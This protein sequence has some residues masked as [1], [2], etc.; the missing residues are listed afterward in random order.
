M[1]YTYYFVRYS[2]NHHKPNICWNSVLVNYIVW[3]THLVFTQFTLVCQHLSTL[4]HLGPSW[5]ILDHQRHWAVPICAWQRRCCARQQLAQVRAR[6]RMKSNEH[7]NMVAENCENCRIRFLDMN[8][9]GEIIGSDSWIK[10]SSWLVYWTKSDD[11]PRGVAT[12]STGRAVVDFWFAVNVGHID[13]PA[14][15]YICL[16]GTEICDDATDSKW[17]QF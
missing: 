14:Q 9:V 13:S 7:C 17:N 3:G 4:D 10:N 15:S 1:K 11:P 12:G 5:T 2:I 8:M 6:D 16:Q